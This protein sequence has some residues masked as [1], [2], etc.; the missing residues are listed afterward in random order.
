MKK[1]I[2]LIVC[3]I[4]VIAVLVAIPKQTYQ[5][6][7]GKTPTTD[8][9][10]TV[11]T[12][13][14]TVYVKNA[15]QKIVGVKIG[16]A[17]IEEDQISQKWDLLTKN[18]NVLPSGYTSAIAPSA[19]LVEHELTNGV[20][21]LH[22]SNDF[23]KSEGRSA[24]EALAWTFCD[25]Q[26]HEVIV[27]IDGEV[28]KELNEYRFKKIAKEIG[29]NMTY[30]TSYLFEATCTTIIHHNGD[31]IIPVTY[32]YMDTNV[33][34]Y[35]IKKTLDEQ[36]VSSKGYSFTLAE[37]GLVINLATNDKLDEKTLLSISESVQFNLNVDYL[38]ING[39]ESVLYQKTFKELD[40]GK[41]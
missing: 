41:A 39:I 32:F 23:L 20:L 22:V 38:T 24:V 18:G 30:E 13:Y 29:V 11:Y 25:D 3:L 33:C 12:E 9:P 7:F 8:N 28:V 10:P 34:D 2:I 15:G 26:I 16:V 4:V 36:M 19:T 27:K 6:W 14:Q 1:K 17:S 37:D 40:P 5:K 35:I 21:T 31:N